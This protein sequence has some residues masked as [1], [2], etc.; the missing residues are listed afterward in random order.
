MRPEG[1][2]EIVPLSL[3]G[4]LKVSAK[5][6]PRSPLQFAFRADESQRHVR[7]LV[8]GFLGEQS[9]HAGADEA[10]RVRIGDDKCYFKC[11]LFVQ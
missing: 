2:L 10:G 1:T 5:R 6:F 4:D 8:A 11:R 7:F 3:R 9:H